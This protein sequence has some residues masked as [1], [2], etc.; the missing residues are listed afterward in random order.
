M[1]LEP[2]TQVAI[3]PSWID[4][5]PAHHWLRD[6]IARLATELTYTFNS[7]RAEMPLAG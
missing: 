1:A 6:R 5:D 2:I 7:Y 3:G 4:A